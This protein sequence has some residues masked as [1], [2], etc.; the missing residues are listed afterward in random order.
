MPMTALA[1]KFAGA[2]WE[3]L[4]LWYGAVAVGLRN[5]VRVRQRAVGSHEPA[6]NNIVQIAVA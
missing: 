1:P 3:K 6:G 5:V 2:K 4:S